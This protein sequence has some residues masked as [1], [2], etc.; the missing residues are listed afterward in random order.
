MAC[1]WRP[2]EKDAHPQITQIK[3]KVFDRL[4]WRVRRLEVRGIDQPICVICGLSSCLYSFV[5][6][7]QRASADC[8]FFHLRSLAFIRGQVS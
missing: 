5:L 1:D 7:I 2:I 8:L 4:T 3:M 6:L